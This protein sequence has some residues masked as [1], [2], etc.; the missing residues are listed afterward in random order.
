MCAAV[1]SLLLYT[2]V[3]MY[4]QTLLRSYIWGF[5]ADIKGRK[6]VVIVSSILLGL[7]AGGF[8]FSVTFTM[9][10]FLRFL[11][12]LFN[13][14]PGSMKAVLSESSD[15]KNQVLCYSV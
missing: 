5:V 12:G 1:F 13:G 2:Y 15:D 9:A 11:V 10:V 3:C 8:G 4:V 14:I 7:A 6:P